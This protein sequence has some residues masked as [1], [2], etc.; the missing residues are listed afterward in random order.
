MLDRLWLPHSILAFA[1]RIDLLFL[2]IFWITMAAWVL[3]TAGMILSGVRSRLRSDRKVSAAEGNLRLELMW[4]S[5]TAI[6]LVTLALMARSTWAGNT[7]A[8]SGSHGIAGVSKV[9]SEVR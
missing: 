4:T 1:P 2:T 9:A 5:A 3:V 6:I 8:A 7:A